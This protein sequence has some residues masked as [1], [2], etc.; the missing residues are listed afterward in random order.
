MSQHVVPTA[1]VE[2]VTINVPAGF[3]VSA[4][5][6][7]PDGRTVLTITPDLNAAQTAALEDFV[8][9]AKSGVRGLKAADVQ[10]LRDFL[11]LA[12]P[13][14]AQ[15]VAAIKALIRTLRAVVND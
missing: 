3:T 6:P 4:G 9:S 2:T 14:N 10:L 8:I 13:T 15:T 11:P 7:Q 12:S 5:A 1:F